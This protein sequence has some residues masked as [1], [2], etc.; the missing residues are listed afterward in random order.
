MDAIF[1]VASCHCNHAGKAHLSLHHPGSG[2][3]ILIQDLPF[4]FEQGEAIEAQQRRIAAVSLALVEA[5][6]SYLGA[7]DGA[8]RR[9]PEREW[10]IGAGPHENEPPNH[11]GYASDSR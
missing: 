7:Q 10:R 2:A 9:W 4:E 1:E 8:H 11:F 6:V 3:R 5:T